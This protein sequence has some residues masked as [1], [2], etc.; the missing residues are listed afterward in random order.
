METKTK[1][2]AEK[3]EKCIKESARVNTK[4]EWE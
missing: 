3:R 4:A 2:T 1:A